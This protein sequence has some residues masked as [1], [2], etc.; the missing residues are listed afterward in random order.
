M[1]LEYFAIFIVV[2]GLLFGYY[3]YE[4]MTQTIQQQKIEINNQKVKNIQ[5]KDEEKQKLFE[6]QS[7]NDKSSTIVVSKQIDKLNN[8][9]TPD[10]NKSKINVNTIKDT[11]KIDKLD[12]NKSYILIIH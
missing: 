4:H 9:L 8:Q 7:Q 5:Q 10:E 6:K 12:S 3:K 2:A 11:S 1:K